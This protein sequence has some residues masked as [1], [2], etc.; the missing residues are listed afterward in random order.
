MSVTIDRY[1]QV[2]DAANVWHV[3]FAGSSSFT[4]VLFIAYCFW[5]LRCTHRL[6]CVFS[7]PSVEHAY[8]FS[9]LTK[10]PSSNSTDKSNKQE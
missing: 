4:L 7:L 1:D 10:E 8:I 2:S 6:I 5:V 3:H 9:I